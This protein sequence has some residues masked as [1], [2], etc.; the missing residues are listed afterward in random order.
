MRNL[1]HKIDKAYPS[2]IGYALFGLFS[3]FYQPYQLYSG[4]T[5]FN[6]YKCFFTSILYDSGWLR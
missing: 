1:L 6:S 4:V 5:K 3:F 2:S